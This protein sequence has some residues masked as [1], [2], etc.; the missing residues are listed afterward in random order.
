MTFTIHSKSTAPDI[1]NTILEGFEKHMGFVPNLLGV[2]AESPFALQSLDAI[3]RAT[4]IS[5]LSPIEQRIVTLTSSLENQCQYCVPAQS[6][7]A[8]MAEMP[9]EILSQL[10]NEEPLSEAKFEGL[11]QFTLKL[12]HNKGWVAENEVLEFLSLGYQPAHVLEVITLM[13]LMTLTNYVSHIANLPLDDAFAPQQWSPKGN[14][15]K[16]L[17]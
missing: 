9:D 10:R 3:N 12:I 16:K 1:S 6:T 7:L 14:T 4:E 15:Q 17:A 11:R 8:R 5:Q 13:S 2:I